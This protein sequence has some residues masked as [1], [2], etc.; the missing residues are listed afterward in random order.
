M[1]VRFGSKFCRLLLSFVLTPETLHC[2]PLD[3]LTLP[4]W[5][6]PFD[7]PW[8]PLGLSAAATVNDVRRWRESEV[9]HGRVAMVRCPS[10]VPLMIA[11]LLAIELHHYRCT[12]LVNLPFSPQLAAIGFIVGEQLQDF[13]LFFNFDGQI[14]GQAI[15]QF[16][17]VKQGF[18]EPLLIAI[19]L[20]ESYRTSIG[21]ATPAG[22]GFNQLK[23][24]GEYNMGD[25]G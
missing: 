7:G 19:G 18:W 15:N 3:L 17:Q 6:G 4:G 22:T 9:T 24:E 8:D 14:T 11:L 20:A 25:L 23:E 13:T 2:T 12:I 1:P 21:W 5:G 10:S 16:S